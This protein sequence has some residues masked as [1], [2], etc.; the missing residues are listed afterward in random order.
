[1]FFLP[2]PNWKPFS[3][4]I[5]QYFYENTVKKGHARTFSS[6]LILILLL[7]I[8]KISNILRNSS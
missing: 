1:M 2:S 6:E 7:K 3:N 4:D 8:Q 5:G